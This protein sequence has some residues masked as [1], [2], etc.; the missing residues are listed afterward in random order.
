MTEK[1]L[2]FAGTT[3]GR[4]IA[5]FLSSAGVAVHVCVA[6]DYGRD[7][8]EG[9]KG[10]TIS[11]GSLGMEGMRSMMADHRLVI[12]ATHPYA[13][14]VKGHIRQACDETG[15]EY[16]R[17]IRPGGLLG[18]DAVVVSDIDSAVEYLSDKE[19]K[20]LV[21]TGSKEIAK[22]GVLGKDRVV[23]RVLP[24]EDSLS[25]CDEAGLDRK[26]VICM[27]GPFSEDMNY[28]L[29][30][31]FGIKYLVTK[32]SGDAGGFGE[33]M[34]AARMTGVIPVVVGRPLREAGLTYGETISALQKRF[35]ISAEGQRESA[36]K[37][38]ISVI[39]TGMGGKGMTLEAMAAAEGA[40]I[41]IGAK[42]MV[43]SLSGNGRDVLE[44][45]A[46]DKI[47]AFLKENRE[48]RNI[49]VL[50]S[51]D[52]GFYSGA[53]KLLD[54]IDGS[55]FD[56]ETYCG[57]SS[58][59]YLCGKLGIPW[60]DAFLMSAHGRGANIPGEVRRRSK[61]F[62]LLQGSEGA[63]KMCSE[64]IEYGLG[65]V[66]VTIGQD[67]GDIKESIFTGTPDKVSGTVDSELCAALIRNPS[68]ETENSMGMD[69]GEF[70]RG[71]APMTKS[72]VRT[73]SV[74]KLKLSNDS[75][76]YD[77]GAGTGSVSVEMARAAVGGKV[78]AIEKDEEAVRLIEINKKKFCTPNV[79]V[80]CGTA[81]EAMT[82]LPAPTHAFIGGSSGNLKQIIQS[83]LT[84]NP[85]VRMVIN[86]V[87]LETMSETLEC[88]R[89]LDLIEE[90]IV[91]I[92]AAK[93]RKAGK[94]HLMT[95]QNPV[96]I[97]TCR[98]RGN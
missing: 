73:L 51:G 10:I 8:M 84:A 67:L 29:I 35:G 27:Q 20:V 23:A 15:A 21:T 74:A 36:G 97:A 26:N 28:A 53:R 58:V 60:E 71:E 94:Y 17:L 1:V 61:V 3:E 44:E 34:S 2:I 81:P 70:V 48:Y 87:T 25:K 92:S 54:A 68:P 95:A 76:I 50:M 38:K 91:S 11:R 18:E 12:D 30:K 78:Y 9:T 69:D 49:A 86:S 66:S 83:L 7:T 55:E 90:D 4:M 37:R 56:A 96:Y 63:R 47:M 88:I 79:E 52:I 5:Q 82:G 80:I 16:L 6:T 24:N 85:E 72:E 43:A 19:G 93:S 46:S 64:L 45:Y 77:I 57:I 32:D 89:D 62:V 13:V 33:K 98:G 41:L 75:V 39:G 65:E 40:D 14:T 22:Y 42:R 59:V 31:Q